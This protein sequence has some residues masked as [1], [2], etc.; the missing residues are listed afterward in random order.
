M[1][2]VLRKRK[3]VLGDSWGQPAPKQSSTSLRIVLNTSALS[4]LIFSSIATDLQRAIA[5]S[6]GKILAQTK[7]WWGAGWWSLVFCKE[8]EKPESK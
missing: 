6:H 1:C 8:M 5:P 7:V 3:K 4:A 2:M